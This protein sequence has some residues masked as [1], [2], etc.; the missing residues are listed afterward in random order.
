MKFKDKINEKMADSPEKQ[1]VYDILFA[2]SDN[3][4]ID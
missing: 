2:L 4:D 3:I 1:Y